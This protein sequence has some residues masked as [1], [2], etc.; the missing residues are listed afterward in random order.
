MGLINMLVVSVSSDNVNGIMR[1]SRMGSQL[2]NRVLEA[3]AISRVFRAG[4]SQGFQ[5][6]LGSDRRRI[7]AGFVFVPLPISI[8]L[9]PCRRALVA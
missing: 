8:V 6:L 7:I 2:Q 9:I 5:C 4:V 3:A 1:A